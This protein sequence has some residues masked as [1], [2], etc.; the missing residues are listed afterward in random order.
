MVNMYVGF[1]SGQKIDLC[2]G[3]KS[4]KESGIDIPIINIVKYV[5]QKTE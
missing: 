4:N 2:M 3:Q 1:K 5:L